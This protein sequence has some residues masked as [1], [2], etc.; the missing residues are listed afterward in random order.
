MKDQEFV[1]RLEKAVAEKYGK[2]AI[3]NPNTNGNPKK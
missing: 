2:E 3:K 1:L